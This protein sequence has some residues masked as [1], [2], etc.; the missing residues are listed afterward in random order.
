MARHRPFPGLTELFNTKTKDRLQ[1]YQLIDALIMDLHRSISDDSHSALAIDLARS[2]FNFQHIHLL[3]GPTWVN[4]EQFLLTYTTS[5]TGG[6]IIDFAAEPFGFRNL[7]AALTGPWLLEPLAGPNTA[8]L[9]PQQ[10][11][12]VA[13]EQR[14]FILLWY[15]NH[16]QRS[17]VC[18]YI[19]DLEQHTL[20]ALPTYNF[21][22]Y[23]DL[24]HIFHLALD[25]PLWIDPQA[26]SN[27]FRS[28]PKADRLNHLPAPCPI[29]FGHYLQNN[30]AHLSRLEDLGILALMDQIFRPKTFDYFLP[31]EE[32]R[33][34]AETNRPKLRFVDSDR[35]AIQLSKANHQALIVSKSSSFGSNLSANFRRSVLTPSTKPEVALWVCVGVRG[36]TRMCLNLVDFVI[37]LAAELNRVANRPIHL[38]IDGMSRSALNGQDTTAGLSTSHEQAIANDII[39]KASSVQS[40]SASSI[41]GLTTFEQLSQ[42]CRCSLAVSGFG[43]QYFKYMYLCHVPTIVHGI[44]EPD[45]YL[46][47]GITPVHLFLGQDSVASVEKTNDDMRHHYNLKVALSTARSVLFAEQTGALTALSTPA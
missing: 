26:R 24:L 45:D 10:A 46:N 9:R 28:L 43:T 47:V 8:C 44:K 16:S 14:R 1:S 4:S 31:E 23:Q 30:L 22:I 17:D 35:E 33:F 36:G 21:W 6:S 41:V 13:P 38:V 18:L 20:Y 2:V 11:N 42:I 29:H 7:P 3:Q 15:N 34:V 40:V 12:N 25:M 27:H 32:K 37:T 19:L 39:A 5:L